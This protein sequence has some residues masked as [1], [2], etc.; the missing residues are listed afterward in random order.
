[1]QGKRCSNIAALL[2]KVGEEL[3]HRHTADYD[4]TEPV[5]IGGSTTGSL[6]LGGWRR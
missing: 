4:K 2:D 1:M 5:R 6:H 3:D